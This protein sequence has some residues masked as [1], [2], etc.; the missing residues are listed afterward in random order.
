MKKVINNIKRIKD[1]TL[2]DGTFVGVH[3]DF[4]IDDCKSNYVEKVCE[5]MIEKHSDIATMG[6]SACDE[7]LNGEILIDYQILNKSDFTN[8]GFE[9]YW[10][11]TY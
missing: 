5:N 7:E 8:Y 9:E 3:V 2:V 10:S 6:W 11:N 1:K 4:G